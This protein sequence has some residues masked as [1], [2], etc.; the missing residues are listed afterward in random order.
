M[1]HSDCFVLFFPFMVH[2]SLAQ[3][4]SLLAVLLESCELGPEKTVVEQAGFDGAENVKVGGGVV[5]RG[6]GA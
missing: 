4:N 2:T 3:V 5:H 1:G 6:P